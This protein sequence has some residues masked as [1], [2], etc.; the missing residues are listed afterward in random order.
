MPPHS[1]GALRR[2][3]AI[4]L[5]MLLAVGLALLAAEYFLNPFDSAVRAIMTRGD[6]GLDYAVILGLYL[7]LAGSIFSYRRWREARVEIAERQRAE[8]ALR[9]LGDELETR[10]AARTAELEQA[11]AALQTEVAGRHRLQAAHEESSRRFRAL[12]EL[13]PD[14]IM[15][16]DPYITG[17]AWPILD[18]NLAACQMN[19]YARDELVGQ[20]IDILNLAPGAP[21]ERHAYLDQ[22]RAAG[23]LKLETQH[24]RKGGEVFPV[25]VATTLITVGE[26]ELI[27]GIDRDISARQRADNILRENEARYHALF[28]ESPISLWEE[29]FSLVKLRLDALRLAGVADFPAH[30]EAHPGLAGELM[31]LTRVL[32]V[33]QATL[34]LFGAASQEEIIQ[35]LPQIASDGAHPPAARELAR[36]AAG[37]TH[38]RYE[39]VN[40]TLSGQRLQVDLSWAA[41]AGH[42]SDLSR[43]IVSIVDVTERKRAEA[44]FTTERNFLRTVIDNMP[45]QVFAKDLQGRF[46]IANP[47]VVRARRAATEAELLGKSDFDLFPREEAEGY[48]AEEAAILHTGTPLVNQSVSYPIAPD[49]TQAWL[50]VT[51]VP[52]RDTQAQVT[53]LVGLIRDISE[54]K[55]TEQ[56]LRDS[57]AYYRLTFD[58]NPLPMWVVDS[59]TLAFLSVNEAAQQHYGYTRAEFLSMTLNDIRPAEDA[60]RLRQFL[61]GADPAEQRVSVWR[62]SK[63]DGTLIEVEIYS[64]DLP[65]GD[66]R[67][68]LILIND[69]TERQQRAR[70]LEAIAALSAALRTART[71]AE[72]LPIILD[73]LLSLFA[74]EAA[75]L[76]TGDPAGEQALTEL[77]R[78]LWAELTGQRTPTSEGITA[79]VLASGEPFVSA[80]IRNDARFSAAALVGGIR[81]VACMPLVVDRRNIGA[82]WIGRRLPLQTPDVRLLKSIAD[83][84]AN[85]LAR[86]GLHEATERHVQQLASLREIDQAIASSLN[87]Q[88]SLNM[89]LE[90]AIQQLGI[91]A[92]DVL[93]LSPGLHT[94]DPAAG[95]GFRAGGNPKSRQRLSEG[96][97]GRA[98]MERQVQH[99]TSATPLGGEFAPARQLAGEGFVEYFGVPLIAK[100]NVSGVLELFGRQPLYPDANWLAFRSALAGQAA[101]AIDNIQLFEG[102]ERANMELALAYDTTIEGWSRALDLRDHE[103]EG[104]SQRVTELTLRLAAA[105]GIAEDEQVHIRRGALLHDIGKMG[106]ADGILLKAGPLTDEEFAQM[107]RHPQLAYD[108]LAPIPYLQPALD[109]PYCHHEKWDGSGYPRGLKGEQI[110][111]AA[112]LFAVADVWDALRSNRPYRAAW[113][114]DK[115]RAHLRALSGAHFDPRLVEVF[116]N[117]V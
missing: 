12:F 116:L 41:A 105:R 26:R 15:L 75:A 109:I 107:K 94:L 22:L 50:Q 84:A 11:N 3:I 114:E 37:Q 33:N 101:V 115:V 30:F 25:E 103:T 93:V 36:I 49:G 20:S 64:H 55:H 65:A 83:M 87:L 112:R 52:L 96:P 27:I 56:A 69:V 86:A 32:A 76:D 63:R 85:A 88:V 48:W 57:E 102:L 80:D 113:P 67:T 43:V 23:T 74:A 92:A 51:K 9:A 5:L 2:H 90:K 21:A 59:E 110:P 111:L 14:A 108:L 72:M 10:V 95:R 13:S 79:Q 66:R 89:L 98:A 24:R 38:F 40:R 16:I 31:A 117:L 47:A 73:Q 58:S 68:R 81:A 106:V 71:R 18:C 4:E 8:A 82:L 39:T 42:E 6:D 44:A 60:A 35:H 34:T 7:I 104:H 78:G 54:L 99:L 46:V 100:G 62:H 61:A 19:G 1:A 77:G 29:D 17:S 97:A 28:E 70:E 53:G 91:D 45:D